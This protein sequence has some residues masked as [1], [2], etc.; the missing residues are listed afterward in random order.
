MDVDAAFLLRT[1]ARRGLLRPGRPDKVVR[2]LD[3]LRRWGYSLTGELR[4]AAARDPRRTAIADDTR[5]VTYGELAARVQRL[6]NG[7]RANYGLA[8]GHRIG[9][10]CRNSVAMFETMLAAGSVGADVLLVN[11]GLGPGQLEAVLRAERVRVLVHDDE[12]FELASAVPPE[13]ARISADGGERRASPTVAGLIAAAPDGDLPPPAQPGRTIVL[14]S[15]TTGAPKGARRPVP[16]SFGP[17]A[18]L[19]SRIPIGARERI[20]IAAPMFHT[21]GYAGLQIA[22]ALR[23]TIV[24]RRR[25]EPADDTGRH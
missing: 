24:V 3:A 1:L 6:A 17:L 15:G 2:Q 21:W 25:F 10:L 5:S 11:I 12:F 9:V 20:F 13:V 18:A 4:S 23:A 8:P 7:L 14:T 22:L 16:G 19:I